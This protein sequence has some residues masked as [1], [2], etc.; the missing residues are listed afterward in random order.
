MVQIAKDLQTDDGY[1]LQHKLYDSLMQL[2][3]K[4]EIPYEIAESYTVRIIYAVLEQLRT[5]NPDKYEHYFLQEWRD[6]QE[7]AFKNYKPESTKSQ[8][9]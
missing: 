6:E 3:S 4:Y 2:M 9:K 8:V 1:G 5:I 7:K